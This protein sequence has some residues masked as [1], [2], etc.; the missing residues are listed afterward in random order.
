M[1]PLLELP[2]V[3]ITISNDG[4]TDNTDEVARA[5]Q[6]RFFDRVVYHKKERNE[7]LDKNLLTCVEIARGEY[8]ICMSD[9]D[10]FEPGAVERILSIIRE[11]NEKKFI[12]INYSR[13]EHRTGKTI[14][15]HMI[16]LDQDRTFSS[17]NEFFFYPTLHSYFKTLGQ[18]LIFMASA[19]FPREYWLKQVPS[20]KKYIGT[21]FLLPCIFL[22]ILA[23]E[24]YKFIYIGS[25]MVRY[26]TGNARDWGNS[27]WLDYHLK[28]LQLAKKLGLD[29][30]KATKLQLKWL[31]SHKRHTISYTTKKLLGLKPKVL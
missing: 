10:E 26:R 17:V 8:C 16:E 25:P 29:N 11:S 30:K 9:D 22:S 14:T 1:A 5:F 24:K 20:L 28:Y 19:V 13:F 18:N 27:I 6:T 31:L 2:G 7:K 15:T 21:N 12:V 4:S 3:E 23:K